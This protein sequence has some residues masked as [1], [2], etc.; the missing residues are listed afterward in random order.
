[1]NLLI[2]NF[3]FMTQIPE[4]KIQSDNE[5]EALSLKDVARSLGVSK[6]TI[7]RWI[8]SNKLEGFFRIGRKWLIRKSDFEASINQRIINSKK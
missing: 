7:L 6:A 5:S 2:T 3:N 1:M 4:V 8:S